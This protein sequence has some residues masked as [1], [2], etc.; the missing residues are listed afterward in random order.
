MGRQTFQVSGEIRFR[1]DL[2]AVVSRLDTA[3]HTLQSEG[4]AQPLRDVRTRPVGAI[5]RGAEALKELRTVRCDASTQFS[6]GMA[7]ISTAFATRFV[8]WRPM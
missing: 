3:D 7:L 5:E 6:G 2:D 1:E 8:P 4:V